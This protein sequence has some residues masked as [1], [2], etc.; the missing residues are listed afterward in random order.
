MWK[1]RDSFN[2]DLEHPRWDARTWKR[3]ERHHVPVGPRTHACCVHEWDVSVMYNVL[4]PSMQ[5]LPVL[6]RQLVTKWLRVVERVG[7]NGIK[8]LATA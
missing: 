4:T 7:S 1:S 8:V 2:Y 3:T 6:L 5:Q